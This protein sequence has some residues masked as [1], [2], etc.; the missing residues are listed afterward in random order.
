MILLLRATIVSCQ[1]RLSFGVSGSHRRRVVDRWR[2]S[3]VFSRMN[4][5]YDYLNSVI[6]I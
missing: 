6:I 1:R 2:R 4:E 3:K 5:C